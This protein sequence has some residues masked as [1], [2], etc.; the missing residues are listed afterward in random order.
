M[1][2]AQ[3]GWVE[4]PLSSTQPAFG[5]CP[6]AR[7]G[8]GMGW[9]RPGLGGRED[10]R[11]RCGGHR[12]LCPGCGFLPRSGQAHGCAWRGSNPALALHPELGPRLRSKAEGGTKGGF[13]WPG[14]TPA[15]RCVPERHGSVAGLPVAPTSA[16]DPRAGL[17]AVAPHPPLP[18]CLLRKD[19]ALAPSGAGMGAVGQMRK[20]LPIL[21]LL[22]RRPTP[23]AEPRVPSLPRAIKRRISAGRHRPGSLGPPGAFQPLPRRRQ[24]VPP[25]LPATPQGRSR[26]RPTMGI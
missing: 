10:P 11:A 24:G 19:Q 1:A 21:Q 16:G 26:W 3:G 23:G 25:E 18:S 7:G 15:G 6:T 22:S 2:L 17:G 5:I 12:G 8:D 20:A 14:R 4:G 9:L 13:W